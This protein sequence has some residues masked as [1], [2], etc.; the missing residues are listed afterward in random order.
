MNVIDLPFNRLVGLEYAPAES[1][2]LLSLPAG[3][4]YHNHLQ[5]VHAG[6]LLALA[7]AASGEFLLRQYGS[8][9]GLIPVVRRLEAKFHKP[10]RGR[11]SARARADAE[12][13]EKLDA[14]LRSKGRALLSVTVE[15]V[16]ESDVVALSA[17][18]QWFIGQ[19]AQV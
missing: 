4:Q 16:D 1:G 11:V 15:V 19:R 6:A 10:A 7:E 2:F 14:E 13:L 17:V 8:V 18:V 5:T 9:P 12:E 3:E